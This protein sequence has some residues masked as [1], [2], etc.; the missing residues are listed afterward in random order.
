MTGKDLVKLLREHGFILDRIE[1]SHHVMERGDVT[2]SVH[3]HGNRDLKKGTEHGILK[4][5]GLR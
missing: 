2:L 5:A 1:G 3:V 4:R